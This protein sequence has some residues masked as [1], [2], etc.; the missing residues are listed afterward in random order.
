MTE[1]YDAVVVVPSDRVLDRA[2]MSP[3]ALQSHNAN[4]GMCGWQAA[5]AD[6]G[7]PNEGPDPA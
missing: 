6:A 1:T 3:R 2:V 4:H 7:H 5:L